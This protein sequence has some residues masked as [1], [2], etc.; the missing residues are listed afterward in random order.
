MLF[1]LTDLQKEANQKFGLTAE[2][3]LNVAQKLYENR[4]ITYP[5]TDSRHL[6]TAMVATLPA[7]LNAL[8]RTELGPIVTGI[9]NTNVSN[10]RFVDDLK[11]TDHTAIVV[12][13]TSP[14]LSTMTKNQVKIYL[15]VAR[16]M[17]GIFL[18]DAKIKLTTVITSCQSETFMSRGKIVLEPGWRVLY[19]K[20][21]EDI[22]PDLIKGQKVD[23]ETSLLS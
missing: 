10:K 21:E 23:T 9:V 8:R 18:P 17:V 19:G 6:T 1:N 20:K 5:R 4:L 22:L 11:V 16:R 2:E 12:T 3:T 14:D 15:L 13:E 7:R